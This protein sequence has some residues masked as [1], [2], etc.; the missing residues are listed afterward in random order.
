MLPDPVI[1]KIFS[2][3]EF[4]GFVYFLLFCFFIYSLSQK[5]VTMLKRDVWKEGTLYH[6]SD[7]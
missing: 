4:L 5:S 6:S 2:I 1:T 7:R 3:A